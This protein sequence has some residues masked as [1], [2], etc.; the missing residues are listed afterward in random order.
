M[1]AIAFVILKPR[2]SAIVE[3]GR[4]ALVH[5]HT[6]EP[7]GRRPPP[8]PRLTPPSWGK[9]GNVTSHR[10]HWNVDLS[11]KTVCAISTRKH[12]ASTSCKSTRRRADQ[13]LAAGSARRRQGGVRRSLEQPRAPAVPRRQRRF[14]RDRLSCAQRAPASSF[15]VS[16]R[17]TEAS[18]VD[19]RARSI[20]RY[21]AT[22]CLV[23][24]GPM[25]FWEERPALEAIGVGKREN[26]AAIRAPLTRP[27]CDL[28]FSNSA[29]ADSAKTDSFPSREGVRHPP[30]T[31]HLASPS[32]TRSSC[33]LVLRKPCSLLPKADTY[34]SLTSRAVQCTLYI[35]YLGS[36]SAL[37][38]C[39]EDRCRVPPTKPCLLPARAAA[40]PSRARLPPPQHRTRS[41]AAPSVVAE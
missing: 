18:S 15:L 36:A 34:Q 25:P 31:R 11:I 12:A 26:N 14:V 39:A 32:Q 2:R 33:H 35:A 3:T 30:A 6:T 20:L 40:Q 27:P 8:C 24:T 23:R 17:P 19:I 16:S 5:R 41:S 21:Q 37:A 9:R 28:F 1:L 10:R 22:L 7:S 4:L 29:V 13:K 38:L